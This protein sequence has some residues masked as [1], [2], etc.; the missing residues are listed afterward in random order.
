MLKVIAREDLNLL[1][2]FPKSFAADCKRHPELRVSDPVYTVYNLEF[3]IRLPNS[4][5]YTPLPPTQEILATAACTNNW[6]AVFKHCD[7]TN[8]AFEDLCQ[9]SGL[10]NP[11]VSAVISRYQPLTDEFIRSNYVWIDW[12]LVSINERISVDV[13]LNH[14]ETVD[15]MAVSQQARSVE[16][17][18]VVEHLVDWE[19]VVDSR[20]MF[21]VQ[22]VRTFQWTINF[23]KLSTKILSPQT[24]VEFADYLDMDLVSQTIPVDAL[25]VVDTV[26]DVID[27]TVLIN[28]HKTFSAEFVAAFY[29][30][31]DFNALSSKYLDVETL[32]QF[33]NVLNWTKIHRNKKYSYT[34]KK[35]FATRMWWDKLLQ[36]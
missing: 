15:W 35:R 19:V 27:W 9:M 26:K 5:R 34:T 8:F 21:D 18:L 7:L 11:A 32:D 22:F 2:R 1:Q 28:S 16:E 23:A 10:A 29:R 6:P 14:R 36:L 13:L 25:H 3:L 30:Y 17:L 12:Q 33:A 20:S 4:T 31:I 24:I